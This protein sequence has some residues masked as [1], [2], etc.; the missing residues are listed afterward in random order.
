MSDLPSRA[1]LPA[2]LADLL[3]HE[4]AREARAVER[5]MAAFAAH[6]YDRVKPPLLEFEDA[7]LSGPGAAIA[8]QTFRLMDPVS[9]RMLALRPDMTLQ[10][11][12]I[13]AT[14]MAGAPR[15][16]RLA[17][18]G[19]VLRV[20]GSQLRPER[21]F[22]QVGVELIGSLSPRADAEVVLLAA[23]AL[24]AVGVAGLS[25]DLCVPTLVPAVC[26]ACGLPPADARRLRQALDRKDA[27]AVADVGGP[28][29]AL[30]SRL[31]AA[32]G[33]ADAAVAALADIDLPAEAAADRDR[34]A[35]VVALVRAAAPDL[36]LTVDPV[37]HRGFEYQTGVSFTLF[38]RGVRGELGAGGRYRAG[39]GD[40]GPG[41]AAQGEPATGFTLY[42]DALLRAVPVAAPPPRLYVPWDA[43]P[44]AAAA[45][46]A[47]GWSAAEALEP[48]ADAVAEA[49]RL[50]CSHVWIDGGAEPVA[51]PAAAPPR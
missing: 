41:E 34:L 26:R 17:Y 48:A 42:T 13:A 30:A 2:G 7:L 44:G 8:E 20:S 19:Q 37:E 16:L 51:G 14:R 29:S 49:R 43:P 35:A 4:A 10:V 21:Q 12:R 40:A 46:R 22:G 38:A 23:S 47:E 50:G 25:A 5:L 1:L 36:M 45:A 6:G 32:S 11:A 33:P 28:A 15:P 27:A 3:P 9:R 31:M 39:A 24:R 18:A